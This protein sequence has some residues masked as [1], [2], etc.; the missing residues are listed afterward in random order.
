MATK[1]NHTL[2]YRKVPPLL[3]QMRE[4]ANLTQR[5]L[6][7]KLRKPQWWVARIET[8]SRRID[9]TEFIF[10]CRGCG[11]DSATALRQLSRHI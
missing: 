6:A 2:S 7:A 1:P 10:F 4:D 3:R 5:Q 11:H 9:V 8:G